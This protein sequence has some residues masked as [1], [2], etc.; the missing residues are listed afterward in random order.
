MDERRACLLLIVFAFLLWTA[1]ETAA[2]YNH[3]VTI[4]AL[5]AGLVKDQCGRWYRPVETPERQ[6]ES[7]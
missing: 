7:P 5:K 6:S 2:Y 4:E 1:F 3:Q